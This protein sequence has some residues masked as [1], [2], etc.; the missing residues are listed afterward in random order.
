MKFELDTHT[1]TIASGHAYS[2]VHD[3]AREAKNIGLKMFA[4]TDHG[5]AMPGGPHI[6]HIGNQKVIP[7]IIDGVFILRGV[8]A[9]IIDYDG[10]LDIPEEYLKELDLVIASLH[11]VCIKP[12]TK[13]ENTNALINAMENR[14]VDII[15]HPG[16][17]VFPIDEEKLLKAAKENNVL[18][19]INNSSFGKSRPGSKD[20]C[21]KIAKMAK[22]M[23]VKLSVGSD[24]H[25]SFQLGK[26][27]YIEEIFEDINMPEDL[28]INTSIHKL[29]NYLEE[30]GK[31][32]I[33]DFKE[34]I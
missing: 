19:E 31:K 12:G 13:E 14:Y 5:P 23:N 26:F 21:I 7:R 8:E 17:P 9:N 22:E 24:T 25:I 32:N 1:H 16:N 20:N 33:K 18:I 4:L 28:I 2:T 15:A 27:N 6:Y 11:D 10:S 29:I 30:K 34:L 3:L